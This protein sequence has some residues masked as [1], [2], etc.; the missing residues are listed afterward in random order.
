MTKPNRNF[1]GWHAPLLHLAADYL[2][3]HHTDDTGRLDLRNVTLILPGARATHRLEE[4]LA[5]SAAK[6]PNPAWYPPEFQTPHA[7]PERFYETKKPVASEVFQWCAWID[8]IRRLQREDHTMFRR[9]LPKTPERFEALLTLGRLFARLHYDLAAEGIDFKK[10]AEMCREIGIESE[11]PR[12]NA[13]AKL[14]TFYASD[15]ADPSKRGFLDQYGLW[16]RQSARLF[17]IREQSNEERQRIEKQLAGQKFY[18]IGLVDMNRLQKE[19]LRKFAAH[20]E[21]LVFAPKDFEHDDTVF[22]EDKRFDEF[23]CLRPE[24]WVDAPIEI[25]SEQ[26]T[27]TGEP[28]DQ[29]DTVL[30]KISAL[31]RPHARGEI[32][33][34]VPSKEVV[35][36]LQH[37]LDRT[38]LVVGTPIQ[39]SGAFRLLKAW[40]QF[41]KS[42]SFADFAT[43]LRHPDIESFVRRKSDEL[44]A[45]DILTLLDNYHNKH[46]PVSVDGSFD[47]DDNNN[48]AAPLRE[49]WKIL[50]ATFSLDDVSTRS[51]QECCRVIESALEV[52]YDSNNDDNQTEAALSQIRSA[53]AEL[54]QL[55]PTFEFTLIESLE[56]LAAQLESVNVPS[57]SG[58]DGSVDDAIDLVGWLDL[59]MDDA[60]AV[61]VTSFQDGIVPSFQNHDLFLPDKLRHRLGVNDNRRR[62]TRDAYALTVLLESR[63][64]DGEVHLIAGRHSASGD[65]QLPSR[66]LFATSDTKLVAERVKQFTGD[67]EVLPQMLFKNAV[68]AGQ[69]DKHA[70]AIPSLP[71]PPTNP[72]QA[73]SVTEFK[74]YLE[75]PYRYFL[76]R[77][78]RLVELDDAALEM[79]ANSFGSMVHKVL[80]Q[81]GK[82]D[83]RDSSSA[84]D[85]R[86][87]LETCLE[88]DAK[89]L[90]GAS[91]RA[92]VAVQIERAR[93]RLAS[94]ATWQVEWRSR[95]WRIADVEYPAPDVELAGLTLHGQIDRIDRNDATNEIIVWDY[96]TGKD[97]ADPKSAYSE[98][99]GEWSDFQL[100]LYRYILRQSR[101]VAPNV[102]IR[103]G[104][105][106]IA[107]AGTAEKIADWSDDVIAAAIDRASEIASEIVSCDWRSVEPV[108]PPPKYDNYAVSCQTKT[109]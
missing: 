84:R 28:S 27:F 24:G 91:P 41:L 50:A 7:L 92:T 62:C 25:D 109:T 31:K 22:H 107:R 69:R 79:P 88:R 100:P 61:I 94:F 30:R 20:I 21:L 57:R 9:L 44:K 99:A 32:V 48:A 10:V 93:A 71:L 98:R 86:E 23:G 37:R 73:I 78:L 75:C 58:G 67:P 12:W 5:E 1:L 90:F 13:L 11:I 29:A 59:A 101:Y 19:I 56:L 54:S 80:R 26:I 4:I 2:V 43:W 89:K 18:L 39:H 77:Q 97:G 8:A 95:G 96:K 47:D 83:L 49:V 85:I 70:F 106:N 82:S 3:A 76:S 51:P 17:A 55:P 35:P 46:F 14:Q 66:F 104:Y 81:F 108:G 68:S 34:C 6:L 105:I 33:V 102:A 53:I 38:L 65:L 42:R 63:K 45:T 64:R 74:T 36:F 87:F 16:D 103:L 72:I 52:C 40:Q 60:P 15:N